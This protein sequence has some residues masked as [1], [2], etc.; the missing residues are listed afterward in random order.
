MIHK[1][2]NKSVIWFFTKF[3]TIPSYWTNTPRIFWTSLR[4]NNEIKIKKT[5]RKGGQTGGGGTERLTDIA[6]F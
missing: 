4:W 1:S 2:R 5:I 3:A 6:S